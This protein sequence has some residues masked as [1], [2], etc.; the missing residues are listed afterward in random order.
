MPCGVDNDSAGKGGGGS[1]SVAQGVA[2]A[3]VLCPSCPAGTAG[4]CLLLD[5]GRGVDTM[6]PPTHAPPPPGG[7]YALHPQSHTSN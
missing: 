7:V 2:L 4:N 3:A 1:R 6:T 5:V